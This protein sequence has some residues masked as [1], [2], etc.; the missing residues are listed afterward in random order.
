M[1]FSSNGANAYFGYTPYVY[2]HPLRKP[3]KSWN[4]GLK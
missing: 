2:P 1:T 4:L 3:P